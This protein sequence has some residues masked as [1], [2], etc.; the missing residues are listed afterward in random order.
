[1]DLRVITAF[2]FAA[3]V[4]SGHG[5]I[6]AL[7]SLRWQELAPLPDS[8][9]VA[10]AFAGVASG[11]LIVAGGANFPDKKPWEGGKKVWHDAIYVLDEPDGEWRRAGKLPRALGYGVSVT[12]PHAVVC[13]GGSDAARQYADVFLLKLADVSGEPQIEPLPSLPVP[14]ANGAGALVDGTLFVVAGSQEP[15]ERAAMN[16]L[17]ALDV[18][19]A[20]AT[21]REL[22]HCPGK[23]RLLPVAAGVNGAFYIFG[24]AA[25]ERN[26]DKARRVYLRDA[27]RYRLGQGWHRLPDLPKPCVA[28]P[29]PAPVFGSRLFLLGGDDGSLA[30]FQPIEQHPGFPNTAL[31]FD[32]RTEKWDVERGVPAPRATVPTA[33]W[34][35]RWVIPSGE[36]KPGV[37]SPEV[38]TVFGGRTK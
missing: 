26:N 17:F 9:G 7:P 27:W 2:L 32:T 11:K 38:W 14:L 23:S 37:R 33:F 24:G 13:V 29:S 19:Q 35:E 12:A 5:E 15:G 31:A 22:E 21:W 20:H 1:V 34:H 16:R 36:T 4:V 30:D 28:A 8:N 3:H 6:A 25:L 18:R 10:G